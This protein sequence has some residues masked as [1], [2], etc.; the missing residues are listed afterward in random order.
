V[1][2]IGIVQD[3]RVVQERLIRAGG[4]LT[5]GA[6]ARN[7]VVIPA[8]DLPDRMLLL[9][10]RRKGYVLRIQQGMTGKLA[11]PIGLYTIGDL[12]ERGSLQRS[13]DAWVLPIDDTVRGKVGLGTTTVL[14]Q[15]VPAPPELAISNR[16]FRP[17]LIERDDPVFFGFLGVF[18]SLAAVAMIYV[19]NFEPVERID[20]EQ[21]T[22]DF[23]VTMA[24]IEE[25]T[26]P[27][28]VVIEPL[29]DPDADPV[30]VAPVEEPPPNTGPEEVAAGG[31]GDPTEPDPG[32]PPSAGGDPDFSEAIAENELMQA[33]MGIGTRGDNN[34]GERISD[35]FGDDV[36]SGDLQ[37]ALDKIVGTEAAQTGPTFIGGNGG[38]GGHGDADLPPG[39]GDGLVDVGV[40]QVEDTLIPTIEPKPPEIDTE[41]KQS[42]T[43]IKKVIRRYQGQIKYC[44]EQALN[45]D[46]TTSGRVEVSID[47]FDGVVED[48]HVV[49]NQ[50]GDAKLGACVESKIRRWQFGDGVN[51]GV[52][53][54][55][56]VTP[57]GG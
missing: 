33:F 53:Y 9:E 22:R 4:D 47:I 10:H 55:F 41:D 29:Q 17:K 20:F 26:D 23:Q 40:V 46:S 19:W 34:N 16:D 30:D 1:L 8:T 11:L 39:E 7:D 28:P 38:G 31:G 52:I 18:S 49:G 21:V 54:P 48:V 36:H 24:D 2:R 14:F 12:I 27:D 13:G 45:R 15:F 56:V 5:I 42:A 25:L 57:K 44:Y 35:V 50:T 37:D 43:A 32:P 51:G 6:S 3:G